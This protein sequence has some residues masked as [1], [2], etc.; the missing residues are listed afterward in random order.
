MLTNTRSFGRVSLFGLVALLLFVGCGPPDSVEIRKERVV[1]ASTERVMPIA[2]SAD[3]FGGNRRT[4]PPPDAPSAPSN[5]T[6]DI[7]EGWRD[8]GPKSM[9]NV[10]LAAGESSECYVIL[11]G[12]EAGGLLA[13]LNRWRNEV[14]LDPLGDAEVAALE[15]VTLLGQSCPLLEVEGNYQGMSG[16]AGLRR[17]LATLLVRPEGSVFVKMVGPPEEIAAH[18]E[19]FLAFV[20]SLEESR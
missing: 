11:L 10:N 18:R 13:N 4:A 6:F 9:R 8:A 19:G 15:Q 16:G 7:P 17:V 3:R 20:A 12:G 14:G 5:L 1:L 2:S